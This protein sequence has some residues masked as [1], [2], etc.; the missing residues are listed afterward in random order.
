MKACWCAC[1]S[2]AALGHEIIRHLLQRVL[3]L[4]GRR[5]DELDQTA[6][7]E[8]LA[9]RKHVVGKRYADR[10]AGVARHVDQAEAL[11]VLL[12]GIPSKEAVRIGMKINGRPTPR[13]MR[14]LREEPEAEIAVEPSQVVHRQRADHRAD[15]DQVTRL[16]LAGEAP[17]DDHHDHG[18]QPTRR[19]HKAR[20]CRRVAEILLHQQRQE[21]GRRERMAPVASMTTK[22]APNCRV[23]TI[24][25]SIIGLR[26][27]NSH[28]IISRNATAATTAN[29]T[30][31]VELNQSSSR[32]R[33]ST[34]SSAPRNVATRTKPMRSNLP[35]ASP[36]LRPRLGFAQNRQETRNRKKSD[37]AVDQK[38]PMPGVIVREPAAKDRADDRCH[39][40]R[41]AE[42]RESLAAFFRRKGI[43][44]DRLRHRHHA[45][46]AKTL[47]DAKQQQR[48]QIPRQTAKHRAC[49]EQSE[50]DHE[51]RLATEQLAR[52][53]L[54]V[55]TDRVGDQVGGHHPGGFVLAHPHAAGDVGQRDVGDGGVEDLHEGRE[56]DQHGD[57]PRI[58]GG[59][60]CRGGRARLRSQRRS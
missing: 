56:R 31:K 10:A 37:R 32:P 28:G 46:A 40:D 60:A 45:A 15:G 58:G 11:S 4:D 30:M 9:M 2:A 34:I 27:L 3:E 6:L 36:S 35:A 17:Y 25:R 14:E 50:A 49:G 38:A 26:R 23:A 59:T 13:S 39:N 41:N 47:Q 54:A 7:M 1:A 43:R 33:S 5:I 55:R 19:Q 8:L 20:P 57:Q 22:Q 44:Q 52:K 16:H 48:L 21:L 51:E 53:L 18:H 12:C 29:P 42:Q 24:R